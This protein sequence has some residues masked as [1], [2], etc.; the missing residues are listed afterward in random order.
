M[1]T[2]T[3][4]LSLVAARLV[5]V[6]FVAVIGF[7]P[8]QPFSRSA[9]AAPDCKHLPP[10]TFPAATI[11]RNERSAGVITSRGLELH[12]VATRGAWRPEGD[13]GCAI[14]VELFTEEGAPP[15]NPGPLIRVRAGTPVTATVRNALADTLWLSGLQ[16]HVSGRVDSIAV[17]PAATREVRFV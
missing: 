12:L 9:S 15:E 1:P 2:L 3:H 13:D 11:N 4:S 7:Q 10:S 17:P 14:D 16:D 5:S 8:R 6:A